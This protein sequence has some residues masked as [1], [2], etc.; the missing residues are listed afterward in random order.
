MP[1]AGVRRCGGRIEQCVSRGDPRVFP[2]AKAPGAA[3]QLVL[4]HADELEESTKAARAALEEATKALE[5]AE[6]A[7][8][9]ARKAYFDA[10]EE[11]R[12]VLK[13]AYDEAEA[14]VPPLKATRAERLASLEQL[15]QPARLE[16]AARPQ[17]DC[18]RESVKAHAR[19][20]FD[21]RAQRPAAG[22][23][24]GAS[25]APRGDVAK[26]PAPLRVQLDV[27]PCVCA[28]E[29]GGATL[30]ALRARL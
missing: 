23:A 22:S 9:V 4:S 15:L 8:S 28:A 7:K 2:Q 30:D 17:L 20:V 24:G 25:A 27:I 1:Q 29:G 18:L 19:R 10:P 21:N 11:Q 14:A 5:A 6:E 16:S 26:A 12:E 3:V 13:A